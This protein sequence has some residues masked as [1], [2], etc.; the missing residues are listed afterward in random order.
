M[1]ILNGL[2][3]ASWVRPKCSLVIC[4][5]KKRVWKAQVEEWQKAGRL[6]SS[7]FYVLNEVYWICYVPGHRQMS[8]KQ[9]NENVNRKT[10]YKRGHTDQDLLCKVSSLPRRF[11]SYY[12]ILISMT[13][14]LLFSF[15]YK[16]SSLLWPILPCDSNMQLKETETVCYC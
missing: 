10:N 15:T 11:Q 12:M 5:S 7:W 13:K 8:N 1:A 3:E 6:S 9:M 16:P 2:W 4:F 14:N